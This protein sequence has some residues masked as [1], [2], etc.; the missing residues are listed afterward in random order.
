MSNA[1]RRCASSPR[2]RPTD[3]AG[4][5]LRP[6]GRRR[7]RPRQ[8]GEGAREQQVADRG[9]GG[10]AGASHDRRAARA[11]AGRRR[12][13]RRGPGSPCGPARSRSPRGPPRRPPRGPAQSRTS[14]GRSR[15]PPASSVARGLG[16]EP[17]AVARDELAQ[18]RPR[19]PPCA[20]AARRR[21]RPSPAVTG[22]GNAPRPRRGDTAHSR[23]DAG[24]D[25]DDPAGEDRVADLARG[26]L[27]SS[28]S[29]QARA[30]TGSAHR[31]GQ[32]ACRR[33]GRR[34]AAPEQRARGGRTTASRR[35]TAAGAAAG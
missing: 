1:S 18:A 30:G 35:S 3:A 15:L 27:G 4:Q 14:I 8:L 17:L 11:A 28:S 19:P 31:L 33:R 23:L 34:P 9:R 6:G 10:P 2:A 24:V 13:R 29:A 21:P 7:A 25:R 16:P 32:V 12:G 20:A 5:Q 26:R 22:G